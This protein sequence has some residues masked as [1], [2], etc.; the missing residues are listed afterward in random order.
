MTSQENDQDFTQENDQDFK[1]I[2]L[3]QVTR[4]QIALFK[5]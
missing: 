1:N 2:I 3:L 4:I 5:V